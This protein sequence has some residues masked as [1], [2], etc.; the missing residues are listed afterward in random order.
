M[1]RFTADVRRDQK[2]SSTR[3]DCEK[4]E[5]FSRLGLKEPIHLG[6]KTERIPWSVVVELPIVTNAG[7]WRDS[8]HDWSDPKDLQLDTLLSTFF[9]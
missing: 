3:G 8:A 4:V 9:F 7:D 6:E 5:K 1:R 2:A